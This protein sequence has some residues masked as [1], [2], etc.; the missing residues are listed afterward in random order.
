MAENGQDPSLKAWQE[1][2][3]RLHRYR[4]D[5]G[6]S[7]QRL[8]ERIP[9]SEAAVGHVERLIRKPSHGLTKELER[10]FGLQGELMELLPEIHGVGPKWFREWPRVEKLAHT[11]R[12]SEPMLIPGL[13]QTERYAS[14]T[15]LG[16][17]GA[18][19]EEIET[20]V[21]FRLRRQ[22]IFARARPPVYSALID[23]SVL[24]RPVGGGA[25]MR[26]Q[27]QKLTDVLN[28][29]YVTVRII[30]LSAG[31][32]AGCL[33]AFEI[34]TLLDGGPTHA[35]VESAEEGRV[36]SRA[37]TVQALTVRWEALSGMAHPVDRSRAI[38]REVME[39]YEQ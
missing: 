24:R 3:E 18:S 22:R 5:Q 13:L 27:L 2:A 12:T 6:L 16:E 9:Y 1:Y 31:L 38:I 10:V 11:I 35:Y 7:Q 29:P 19:V 23:E 34:A 17:P 37:K 20:A 28:P 8:A 15:F 32:T 33:G 21:G 14:H 25:V 39:S 30:P 36:T 4:S 26:E